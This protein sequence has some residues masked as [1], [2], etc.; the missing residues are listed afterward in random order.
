MCFVNMHRDIKN[1]MHVPIN[2]YNSHWYVQWNLKIC[3]HFP[4]SLTS[5][6]PD[7]SSTVQF[8]WYLKEFW[9]V[10]G[11]NKCS[12]YLFVCL[13]CVHCLWRIIWQEFS[14]DSIEALVVFLPSKQAVPKV[15]QVLTALAEQRPQD[16]VEYDK[17]IMQSIKKPGENSIEAVSTLVQ[18]S[19][20]SEVCPEW[21]LHNLETG[22]SELFP[23]HRRRLLNT[24][25]SLYKYWRR[26][27]VRARVF[28]WPKWKTLGKSSTQLS[29]S[30]SLCSDTWKRQRMSQQRKHA[31]LASTSL[32]TGSSFIFAGLHSLIHL[33]VACLVQSAWS[34]H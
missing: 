5:S 14:K 7:L 3:L 13:P 26:V 34:I 16:V 28:W 24:R 23:F 20:L 32:G 15:Y 17:K 33:F 6:T 1:P 18:L 27:T 10:A 25:I 19:G 8:F 11:M 12:Q 21:S 9:K 22:L 30:I 2:L 31:R 4:N 29:A